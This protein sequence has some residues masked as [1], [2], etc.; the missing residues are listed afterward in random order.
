MRKPVIKDKAPNL[1]GRVWASWALTEDHALSAADFL[2]KLPEGT[3]FPISCGTYDKATRGGSEGEEQEA[4]FDSQAEGWNTDEKGARVDLHRLGAFV[5][6]TWSVLAEPQLT[7][8]LEGAEEHSGLECLMWLSPFD[9]SAAM[10]DAGLLPVECY[11]PAKGR[12]TGEAFD[13]GQPDRVRPYAK[14]GIEQL[15]AAGQAV[16]DAWEGGNLAA[17]VRNLDKTIQTIRKGA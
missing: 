8:T 13:F 4:S 1:E 5:V 16:V 9:L 7:D 3:E 17:A 15:L 12:K 2:T 6:L 14:A 10:E 11:D